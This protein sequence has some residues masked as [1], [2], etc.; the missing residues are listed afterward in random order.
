MIIN[1][2]SGEDWKS[3]FDVSLNY[4]RDELN[5]KLKSSHYKLT[6]DDNNK[7]YKCVKNYIDGARGASANIY[8]AMTIEFTDGS[9]N[10]YSRD[11]GFTIYI[12]KQT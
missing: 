10:K 4:N 3:Y 5:V 1:T 2:S 8:M 11:Y 6:K 7:F 9:G 12:D